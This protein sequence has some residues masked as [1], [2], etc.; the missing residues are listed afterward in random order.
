MDKLIEKN[1][2]FETAHLMVL[3]SYTIFSV[4]LISES[5]L[6]GWE[7]W[8][9]PLIFVSNITAWVIH[10]RQAF[11]ER[12][13]VWVYAIFMMVT[14]FFYGIHLTSTYDIA[15]VIVAVMLLYSATDERGLI[16]LCLITY[17]MAYIYDLVTMYHNGTKWTDLLVSR[18]MLHFFIVG[19]CWWI[20][21]NIIKKWHATLHHTDE[22]IAELKDASMRMDDFMV[23]ISHEIRTPMNAVVGLSSVMIKEA[24][25]QRQ[26]ENLER[27]LDA[28]HRVSSQ[29]S[30]ILDHTEIDMGKL[31]V[32]NETY[33]MSSVINDVI[34][35]LN[36]I[37]TDDLE[38]IFD[39]DTQVP[40][41]LIGDTVK[42]KKI[43]CHLV[44]NSIK[45]TSEGGVYVRIK[46]ENRQYGVNLQIEVSDTGIGM[47]EDEIDR[48]FERFYQSDSGRTRKA[49]GLGLGLSIVQGFVKAM[50]GFLSIESY[51]GEGTRVLVSLPQRIA[52]PEPCVT[53]P[54]S[55]T[56]CIVGFIR[57]MKIPHP[58]VRE[59]YGFLVRHLSESL[60][61]PFHWVDS[62]EQ[63]EKLSSIYKIS[64]LVI[65]ESEYRDFYDRMV[66][67]A[68]ETNVI[69]F[70]H[71]SFKLPKDSPLHLLKKP[72]SPFAVVGF[73]VKE[74]NEETVQN[75]TMSCPGIR[76]LV[77][78]DEPMNIFV[79]KDILE[80]YGMVVSGAESGEESIRMFE[81]N[82][83]DIIFM[84]HMMPG[85][86]GIEAMKRLRSVKKESGNEPAIVALTANAVSAAKEMFLRE[87]FDGFI[88]KPIEISEFERVLKHVLPKSAVVYGEKKAATDQVET[89]NR[90]A[91]DEKYDALIK[92]GI[93][94]KTGLRYCRDDADFYDSMLIEFAKSHDARSEA[95]RQA[96]EGENWADY[97][98][99]VHAVKSTA[100]MIGAM[101]LSDWAKALEAAG[102][103]GD[104]TM[105]KKDHEGFEFDYGRI[106]DAIRTL[107]SDGKDEEEDADILEFGP[108]GESDEIL[109]FSPEG[110]TDD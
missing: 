74:H 35:Q 33:M 17:Y 93:D 10:L 31:A 27:I 90:P 41:A 38:V 71:N 78:D 50:G 34:A 1:K 62:M 79:A 85:M 98:I 68:A 12:V 91:D 51:A 39:V 29:I 64:H 104:G 23:N 53:I 81:N 8:A 9:L 65:G 7:M 67:Y 75:G 108:E 13:R 5:L 40:S 96:F 101:E 3:I 48:V 69:L 36:P 105:I 77:V 70:A 99:Y 56:L 49:G 61:I 63:L 73:K 57:F 84:D 89:D 80:G 107:L 94:I 54:N 18:S 110:E 30:D 46:S 106:C 72:L 28:G 97:A 55:D 26:K 83:Y 82:D 100:R 44:T 86:D 47:S 87:G 92:A 45:F 2:L 15:V 52:D 19:M 25:N 43:I 11:T 6:M 4:I 102:K 24:E 58:V 59:N 21:R 60:H 22:E 95:R 103:A 66:S 88:P 20:C 32:N 76:A 14:F 42:I 16:T 37:I 109:E